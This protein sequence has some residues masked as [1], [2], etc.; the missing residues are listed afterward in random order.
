MK[1]PNIVEAAVS[2]Q[3]LSILVDA[4]TKAKLVATLTGDGP[5]TVFAPNN[6]AFDKIPTAKLEELL[7]PEN[8]EMLQ[9]VLQRH[10]LIPSLLSR[11]IPSGGRKYQTIDGQ[12]ITITNED[13]VTIESVAG[14]ATVVNA[15]LEA[16]NGVIH[17]VDNVF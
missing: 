14:K 17:I 1:L 5:F 7:N 9:I 10:V 11:D 4:V 15:D 8:I 2:N 13:D 16:S 12:T 3:N 6:D